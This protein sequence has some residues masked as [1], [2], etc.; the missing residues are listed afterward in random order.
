[1]ASSLQEFLFL[2]NLTTPM[3]LWIVG[4][5]AAIF[6]LLIFT[7]R[8]GNICWTHLATQQLTAINRNYVH[9]TTPYPMPFYNWDHPLFA[10]SPFLPKLLIP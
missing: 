3:L 8:I 6:M 9:Q 5:V 2:A 4:A 7:L 10:N 1:L